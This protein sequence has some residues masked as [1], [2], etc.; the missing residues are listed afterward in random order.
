MNIDL[1][2]EEIEVVS[3]GLESLLLK[4]ANFE[5]AS[6]VLR[7]NTKLITEMGKYGAEKD[8]VS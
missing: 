8:T 6:F 5:G 3:K 4:G 1:T 2:K 7:L